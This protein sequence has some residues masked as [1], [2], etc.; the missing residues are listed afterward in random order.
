MKRSKWA[1]PIATG[2]LSVTVLGGCSGAGD[3]A[4]SEK[5]PTGVAITNWFISL[6]ADEAQPS[7]AATPIKFN[8]YICNSCHGTVGQGAPLIG[9]ELRHVDPVLATW[10]VRNG[11]GSMSIYPPAA[12]ATNPTAGFVTDA[13]LTEIVTWL[14]GQPKP[15]TPEGL[16][17]DF[18]GNCHGPATNPTGGAVPWAVKGLP[19]ATYTLFVRGGSGTDPSQRSKY[20]PKFDTTKLTDAELAQITTF[21][22]ATP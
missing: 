7:A 1:G 16:Y 21:L 2:L 14:N 9:P 4:K 6:T 15:T 20:M 17:K 8:D 19:T 5:A 12:P 3:P 22:G 18:C 11:R 10:I 13:E